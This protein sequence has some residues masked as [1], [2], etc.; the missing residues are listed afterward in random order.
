[1]AGIACRI[2]PIAQDPAYHHFSDARTLAGISFFLNV[3]SNLPFLI[4]GFW[5]LMICGRKGTLVFSNPSA[6]KAWFSLFAGVFA[7]GLGSAWYHLAPDNERLT[8]DRLP[9][10]IV[11]MSFCAVL[12]A[13]RISSTGGI[14]MLFVLNAIGVFSVWYW[15]TTE[16][17]GAGDL[18]FYALVQFAPMLVLPLLLLLFREG[19]TLFPSL[20][21]V[22]IWYVLAKILEHFDA[23]IYH[24]TGFVSGHTLKHLAAS[25][26]VYCMLAILLARRKKNE[27]A[28]SVL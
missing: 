28:I 19:P 16:L 17:S 25:G 1:M 10:T 7:V 6:R 21:W 15:H 5:G 14:T 11:F 26:A 13:E 9:M 2:N 20:F 4:I 8:W 12:V 18:R 22:F 3:I 23:A 24:L 27:N